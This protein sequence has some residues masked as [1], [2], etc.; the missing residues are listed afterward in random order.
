MTSSE[1]NALVPGIYSVFFKH[2]NGTPVVSVIGVKE[3]EILRPLIIWE[4]V[5]HVEIIFMLGTK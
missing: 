5:D 3:Y 4:Y 1:V 2:K